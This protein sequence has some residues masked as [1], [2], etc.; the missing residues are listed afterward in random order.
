MNK[1]TR[2]EEEGEV[3]MEEQRGTASRCH[4][5]LGQWLILDVT[6]FSVLVFIFGDIWTWVRRVGH[7]VGGKK[8]GEE[9]R[10]RQCSRYQWLQGG[11][12]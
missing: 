7:R 5:K 9:E 12:S 3:R 11:S 10:P 8:G 6:Q 4:R 2:R 1:P